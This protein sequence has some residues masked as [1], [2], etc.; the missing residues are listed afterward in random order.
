[1]TPEFNSVGILSL[2]ALVML[3]VLGGISLLAHIYN[4]KATPR[5]HKKANR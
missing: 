1:M 5:N 3:V 4:L 2:V